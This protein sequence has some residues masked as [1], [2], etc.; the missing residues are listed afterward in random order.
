MIE[1]TLKDKKENRRDFQVKTGLRET[2]RWYEGEVSDCK[3]HSDGE[4]SE[5]RLTEQ[6]KTHQW[7]KQKKLNRHLIV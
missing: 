3:R 5:L 1:R 6:E 7:T 4:I 2:V